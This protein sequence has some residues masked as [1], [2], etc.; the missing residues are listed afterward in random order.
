[1][2]PRSE[3][4][5]ELESKLYDLTLDKMVDIINDPDA[6]DK[7]IN[8]VLKFLKDQKISAEPRHRKTLRTIREAAN[9]VSCE[10]LPF[11]RKAE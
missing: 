1:M 5:A 4:L 2:T 3:K 10:N 7:H 11:Q 6:D 8:L 9:K